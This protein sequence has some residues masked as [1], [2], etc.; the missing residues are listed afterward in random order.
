VINVV[1]LLLATGAMLVVMLA[2]A[3][4]TIVGI[5]WAVG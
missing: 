4:L 1:G 3:G 5:A 2:V